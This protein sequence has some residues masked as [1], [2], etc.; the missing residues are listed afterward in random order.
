MEIIPLTQNHAATAARLHM[1]GQPGTFLTSLG[2]DVLTV[3]YQALP[4]SPV[5]FGFAAVA[6]S[7]A[8]QPNQP[9]GFVSATTSIGKLLFEMGTQRFFQFLPPLLRRYIR[10]PMLALRSVQ[11]VLY[12]FLGNSSQP[13]SNSTEQSSGTE[14]SA[15]L[16]SIMVE[17]SQ[18]S[19]G[20]GAQLI[21]RLFSEC[22]TRSITLLDVTVDLA[23]DGAQRFYRRHGFVDHHQFTLYGRAMTSMRRTLP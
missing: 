20:I 17:P 7:T 9:A 8:G 13:E 21:E 15:E 19:S 6:E 5:G 11:T 23:N 2:Q 14:Q 18:R 10:Q 3:L 12:P 22:S 1:A 4:Q 16:L